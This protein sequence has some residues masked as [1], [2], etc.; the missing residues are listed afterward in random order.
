MLRRLLVSAAQ[1]IIGPFGP[2]CDLRSKGHRL[3]ERGGQRAKKKAIVAVA[4]T[5]AVVMLTLWKKNTN[6]VCHRTSV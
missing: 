3:I 4:R 6:Y 1:Y 2:E 5:L